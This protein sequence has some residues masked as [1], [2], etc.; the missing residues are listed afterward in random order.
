MAA[1]NDNALSKFVGILEVAPQASPGSLVRVASVRGLIANID[2]TANQVE[3]KAD[4][5]GTVF[6]GY[7]PEMRIEGSFLENADR[8]LI[9]LLLGGTPADVAGSIVNNYSQV[10]AS[11]AWAYNT[12]IPFDFQDGDGTAP[13]VDSVTGGTDGALVLNTDY[14]LVKNAQGQWG[15]IVIDS[16]TVTTLAQTMTIQFDYTPNASENLT[17]PVT[18]TESER[19]YVKITATDE[20]GL[21]DRIIILDDAT[22]EGT[23]GLEFLDV[24]EAGDL[25]GTSFVFKA[26]KGSNLIIQNEIL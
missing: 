3:V 23:F 9:D 22:F 24:V 5:T 13:V 16:A 15:I 4:D 19:L 21:K 12:F 7:L 10:E 1:I 11:G 18:F 20:T 2:N 17:I 8:D 14:M 6:K 26:A 25:A